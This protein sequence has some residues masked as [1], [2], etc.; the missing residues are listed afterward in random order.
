MQR[1]VIVASA[2]LGV[3]VGIAACSDS[4][5]QPGT[6][7]PEIV[8]DRSSFNSGSMI[9]Q[10][11][12]MWAPHLRQAAHPLCSAAAG[13]VCQ[14]VPFFPGAY[15]IATVPSPTGPVT[16]RFTRVTE[17]ANLIVETAPREFESALDAEELLR[18]CPELG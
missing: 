7:G 14:L 6:V 13:D 10:C 12:G 1:L 16:V 15:T 9:G 3:V 8:T 4:P 18:L 2:V 5:V 11:V 17:G